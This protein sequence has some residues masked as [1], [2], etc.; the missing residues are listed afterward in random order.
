MQFHAIAA[1]FCRQGDSWGGLISLILGKGFEM[2]KLMGWSG[3]LGLSTVILLLLVS[4]TGPGG[5]SNSSAFA[6]DRGTWK[7]VTVLYLNDVKGKI[8]PCG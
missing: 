7:N 6:A 8:D 4:T 1:V 3:L 5:S 2:T